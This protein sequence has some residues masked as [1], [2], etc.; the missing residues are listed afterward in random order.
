MKCLEGEMCY[1]EK[2]VSYIKENF[3]NIII[4]F[5]LAAIAI[6]SP[7]YADYLQ[8]KQETGTE[9][10][11]LL[12]QYRINDVNMLEKA[13]GR[14]RLGSTLEEELLALEISI[15]ILEEGDYPFKEALGSALRQVEIACEFR[16]FL[17]AQEDKYDFTH[18]P[19]SNY[20]DSINGNIYSILQELDN[21]VYGGKIRTSEDIDTCY[22]E[23]MPDIMR[24]IEAIQ[25]MCE[26][27]IDKAD[28]K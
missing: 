4:L 9:T 16:E 28:D 3:K 23:I 10:E 27:I 24:E 13:L 12:C 6:A 15:V 18:V 8:T 22:E 1:M 17:S 19:I 11:R 2:V 25:N 26:H 14:I 7:G 21:I 5:L 20:Y